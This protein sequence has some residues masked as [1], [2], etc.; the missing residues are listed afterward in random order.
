MEGVSSKHQEFLKWKTNRRK[1]QA[2]STLSKSND[3]GALW[4][5]AALTTFIIAL[6]LLLTSCPL[7]SGI[8]Y[9][10]PAF[11]EKQGTLTSKKIDHCGT[12]DY[13]CSP[14]LTYSYGGSR[15]EDQFGN[16]TGYAGGQS[17]TIEG[18]TTE[19]NVGTKHIKSIWSL[20]EGTKATIYASAT[21]LCHFQKPMMDMFAASMAM[22]ILFF[23][24]CL[25]CCSGLCT[26]PVA[27]SALYQAADDCAKADELFGAYRT[28]RNDGLKYSYFVRK[29]D[30][31]DYIFV[32][33]R[34]SAY[35]KAHK[36][37]G[38]SSP[39]YEPAA[40]SSQPGVTPISAALKGQLYAEVSQI[41][42]KAN[43]KRLELAKG[44]SA[45]PHQTWGEQVL[46]WFEGVQGSTG[47]ILKALA[48]FPLLVIFPL[49][50]ILDAVSA[51]FFGWRR[52][53]ARRQWFEDFYAQN[54]GLDTFAIDDEVAMEMR[55]LCERVAEGGPCEVGS[56]DLLFV[57]FTTE[58]DDVKVESRDGGAS[59]GHIPHSY[60][61]WDT[62]KINFYSSLEALEASRAPPRTEEEEAPTA[63]ASDSSAVGAATVL[64]VGE[65][66]EF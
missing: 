61:M 63:A 27:E 52:L 55:A 42:K 13:N 22:W 32:M 57:G 44:V 47:L 56:G 40:Y 65:S 38:G 5:C 18:V 46:G 48:F 31:T 50:M 29:P 24:S 12:D 3:S 54:P 21:N 16:Y 20:K 39:A 19:T 62:F 14:L 17:C 36:V 59:T 60:I 41:C 35:T 45:C 4:L 26:V 25:Q 1:Y 9:C 7:K 58:T 64:E 37:P 53:A 10:G 49:I 2:F 28:S 8:D 51:I 23:F 34:R 6:I 43:D 33:Q 15:M 66:I 30:E 11:S